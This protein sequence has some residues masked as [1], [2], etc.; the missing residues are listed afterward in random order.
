MITKEEIFSRNQKWVD[1]KLNRDGSY[2]DKLSER[3]SPGFIYLGS[4]DTQVVPE[5]F[6]GL[7]PGEAFVTRNMG[8]LFYEDDLSIKAF[9]NHAILNFKLKDI[10]VCG[11]Y[12]CSGV[13]QVLK[14]SELEWLKKIRELHKA[15]PKADQKKLVELNVIQ[16]CTDLE[17]SDIVK[18]NGVR[19][20]PWV[21]DIS[22]GKIVDLSE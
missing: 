21:F 18:E 22:T 4:S 13:E 17:E 15:N 3:Q 19:I 7:E 20:Y 6:M 1:Q 2:F 5:L 12:D 16:Q 14:G 8:N 9:L 10:V 11:H